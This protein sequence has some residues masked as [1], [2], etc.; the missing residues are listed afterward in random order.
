MTATSKNS[1]FD[2]LDDIFDVYNNT[3]HK[4]INMRPIDV[5]SNFWAEYNEEINEKKILNLK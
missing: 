1:Y 4:A 3:Y 2:I 5:K